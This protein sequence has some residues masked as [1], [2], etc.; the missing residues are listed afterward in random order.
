MIKYFGKYSCKQFI[1]GKPIRFGYKMW[2]L[3]AKEGYLINFELYQGQS[4]KSNTV[5][6][7]LFGKA[8]ASLLVLLDELPE[9]KRN[10]RYH[11]HMD[12]LFSGPNLFSYLKFHG[13]F[14]IGTI[15]DNHIPANCPI[16]SK[17]TFERKNRGYFEKILEKNDGLLY[18]RWMDNAIVTMISSPYGT[19]L[20]SYVKRYSQKY[21]AY[22]YSYTTSDCSIQ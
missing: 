22:L 10:L 3:N 16:T 15:Q 20:V 21:K 11:I 9:S 12:N 7:L 8:S 17:K 18:I 2:R 4:S 13:Y 1:R 6:G 5:Y 14:A 19:Q